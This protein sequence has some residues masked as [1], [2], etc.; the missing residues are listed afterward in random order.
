MTVELRSIGMTKRIYT[1][2]FMRVGHRVQCVLSIGT[3]PNDTMSVDLAD[4][5]L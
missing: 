1:V 5:N 2:K 3:A 4:S